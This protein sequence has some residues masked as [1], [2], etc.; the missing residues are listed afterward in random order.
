MTLRDFLSISLD[1]P[2]SI[3]VVG[4]GYLATLLLREIPILLLQHLVVS[5]QTRQ[6][7]EWGGGS[8]VCHVSLHAVAAVSICQSRAV[9]LPLSQS[10]VS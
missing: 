5:V 2:Q 9:C 4:G 3:L 7:E 1:K 10:E 6:K 8:T